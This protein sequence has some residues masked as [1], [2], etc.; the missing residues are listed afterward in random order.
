MAL[1]KG[2]VDVVKASLTGSILGNSLLVLGA[3][4]LAGGLRYRRQQF[5]ATAASV[6][7]TLLILSATSLILPATFHHLVGNA[8]F[9]KKVEESMSLP[10]SAILLFAYALNLLFS[11]R[12][13]KHLY[14]GGE[15]GH[16][17]AGSTWSLKASIAVLAGTTVLVA[18]LSEILVAEVEHVSH[19][20]GLNEIF[21]GV[22]LIAFFG[23][24]AEHS[25][26]ILMAWKDRMDIALGITI[27]SSTQIALFVA[28]VLVFASL[29][30]D[31]RLDLVFSLSEVVAVTLS[32]WIVSLVCH[33]GECHWLE[34]V[35]LL[36][37][38]AILGFTFYYLPGSRASP[39]VP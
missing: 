1:R 29:G 31:Q 16:A 20:W 18:V 39:R 22:V 4:I 23:N 8:E 28:P 38:Y 37:L 6:G 36:A 15:A 5:N 19:Q 7:S 25:S 3:A 35:L 17:H 24:A 26:A 30:M 10:L 2:L 27:G 13:H 11:F 33:D 12:T 14:A 9:A 21:V 32:A 34:G